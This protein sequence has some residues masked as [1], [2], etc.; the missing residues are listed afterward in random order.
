VSGSSLLAAA[1]FSVV[2]G[3]SFVVSAAPLPCTCCWCSCCMVRLFSAVVW[4]SGAAPPCNLSLEVAALTFQLCSDRDLYPWALTFL[5]LLLCEGL[6]TEFLCEGLSDRSFLLSEGLTSE[7][8]VWNP[9]GSIFLVARKFLHLLARDSTYMVDLWTGLCLSIIT[10][11]FASLCVAVTSSKV[12]L[13]GKVSYLFSLSDLDFALSFCFDLSRFMYQHWRLSDLDC[14][15][16]FSSYFWSL[17]CCSWSDWVFILSFR[18]VD[19]YE[20]YSSI[21]D[22]NLMIILDL[23]I[24]YI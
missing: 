4:L 9:C 21:I 14:M 15:L 7:M 23:P 5:K 24:N 2:V 20:F 1:L 3:V 22:Q 6:S 10:N 12:S 19:L 11:G 17:V 18:S 8:H 16:S 13:P